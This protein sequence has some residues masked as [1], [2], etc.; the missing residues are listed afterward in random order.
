[1][2]GGLAPGETR[3][4]VASERLADAVGAAMRAHR[5]TD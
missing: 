3:E 5:Q 1:V 2:I 4:G